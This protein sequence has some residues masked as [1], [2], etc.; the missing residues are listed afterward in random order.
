MKG[1]KISNIKLFIEAIDLV[2]IIKYNNIEK[3]NTVRFNN[4]IINEGGIKH[5]YW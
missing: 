5:E 2:K 4:V 1:L 3:Y